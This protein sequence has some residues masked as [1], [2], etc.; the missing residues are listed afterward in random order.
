MFDRKPK[1]ISPVEK[2]NAPGPMSW[3]RR[4]FLLLGAA[5]IVTVIYTLFFAD[6]LRVKKVIVT[7]TVDLSSQSIEMAVRD[8]LASKRWWVIPGNALLVVK[9]TAIESRLAN[10]Y[11]KISAVTVSRVF[12]DM[13]IVQVI[14]RQFL[15]VWCSG[16][17]C[18]LMDGEGVPYALADFESP[19][20]KE[21][22]GKVVVVRDE[23]ASSIAEGVALLDREYLHFIT[24]IGQEIENKTGVHLRRK[25]RTPRAVAGD[26]A[27]DTEE[28]WAVMLSREIGIEKSAS[29]L[30][31]VLSEAIP[32]DK[33]GE[34]EYIDLR[35]ENKVYYKFKNTEPA[36]TPEDVAP[37]EEDKKGKDKK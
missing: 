10:Q 14:E 16:E 27:V 5:F 17:K 8:V 18:F 19:E 23:S 31:V 11:K 29:S 24:A 9:S 25:F 20:I 7:G 2:E 33:R 15:L 32:K 6:F 35:T 30:A 34:L 22:E 1:R 37:A 13:L 28:G 3:G 4:L 26:I 36:T 21:N 12:P